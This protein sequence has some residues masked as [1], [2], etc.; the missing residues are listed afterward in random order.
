MNHA[1]DPFDLDRFVRPKR[2]HIS[3]IQCSDHAWMR[4]GGIGIGRC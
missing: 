1:D 2:R 4:N 3:N